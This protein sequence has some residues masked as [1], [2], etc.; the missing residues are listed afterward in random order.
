MVVPQKKIIIL[1]LKPK[2]LIKKREKR[3]RPKIFKN[4]KL[5]PQIQSFH[6]CHNPQNIKKL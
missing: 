5:T 4:S 2:K 3:K 1:R 6:L